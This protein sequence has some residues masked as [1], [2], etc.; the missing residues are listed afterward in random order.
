MDYSEKIKEAARLLG[1]LDCGIIPAETLADDATRLNRWLSAGYQAGMTWMERYPDKRTNPALLVENAR[2]VIVVLLN[3]QTPERQTDPEAPVVSKYAYGRDYHRVAKKKLLKLLETIHDITGSATGRAFIDSAP[4]LE[5]ALGRRAGLGWIGKNSML[6]SR[7]HGSFF[8]IGT[9]IVDIGLNYDRPVR[10]YCGSCTRCIDACPTG[11]IVANKVVDA[12]RCI[13]YWTIENK[14]NTIPEEFRDKFMNRVFG[15]DICQDACPW[16]H[17]TPPHQEPA[18]AGN[19]TLLSMS[20]DQWYQ[21]SEKKYDE[22]FQGS[23]LKRACYTGLKRNLQF[24]KNVSR[25]S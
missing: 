17:N 23:S 22:L 2:S 4:V 18:L 15:C 13:S 20:K 6:L 3:Y 25:E 7:K 1:F 24:L 9:L 16:N 12:N 10:E 11:A 19:D 5:R 8:F 14:G 21:M